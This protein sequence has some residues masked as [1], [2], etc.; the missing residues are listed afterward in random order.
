[1]PIEDR[2]RHDRLR[3]LLPRAYATDPQRHALGVVLETLADNL[4]EADHAVERALRDRW[5]RTATAAREREQTI[6]V[7]TLDGW[8]DDASLP[9]SMVA[10]ANARAQ[11]LGGRLIKITAPAGHIHA[12]TLSLIEVLRPADLHAWPDETAATAALANLVAPL[13]L[14]LGQP[15]FSD[16]IAVNDVKL[17]QR[18]RWQ[19]GTGS[20]EAGYSPA[21]PVTALVLIEGAVADWRTRLDT[22]L[23]SLEG[24]TADL[25][26]SLPTIDLAGFPHPLELLGAALALHRQPWEADVESYRNRI[27]ILAPMLSQGLATPRVM[28]AFA[29]T[30]LHTEPCPI[31]DQQSDSTRGYGLPPRTLDRCRVCQGGQ[32]RPPNPTQ[33]AIFDH[34]SFDDASFDSRK[35]NFAALCPMASRATIEA[36]I[37]ENPRTR[38]RFTRSR[39]DLTATSPD[40]RLHIY[41]DSLFSARPQIVLR[42]LSEHHEPV[43]LRLRSLTTGEEVIIPRQLH[44]GDGLTI[45]PASPWQ[46]GPAHQQF[47]VDPPSGEQLLPAR[48]WVIHDDDTLEPLADDLVMYAEGPRFGK[49]RFGGPSDAALFDDALFDDVQFDTPEPD[50][51]TEQFRFAKAELGLL[52]PALVP[53]DNQWLISTLSDE[54]LRQL[55]QDYESVPPPGNEFDA[56]LVPFSLELSWWTRPPARFRIRIPRVPAVER[57]VALGAATYLRRLVERV[58]P[59]GVQAIIDFAVEPIREPLTPEVGFSL[60][61]RAYEALEPTVDNVALE[62]TGEAESLEPDEQFGFIGMLDVTHFDWSRFAERGIEIGVFDR[63]VFDKSQLQELGTELAI[64]DQTYFDHAFLAFSQPNFGQAHLDMTRFA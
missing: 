32:R 27:R 41:N 8:L 19:L 45:R 59:A 26:S 3:S 62:H 57:V 54:Q 35:S 52:T 4:R 46:S 24:L 9:A 63:T 40:V 28:L 42:V 47:W 34:S 49:A 1:M 30:S 48:A 6:D 53:G 21:G 44:G 7:P 55:S 13:G 2:T 10:A 50:A 5:L 51:E 37:T 60:D 14:P 15:V 20:F 31:L 16:H 56:A 29:L 17:L 22:M 25:P 12:I 39:L 23:A 61:V 38:V 11:L 18:S 58:R 43:V 64:L 33:L 36:T